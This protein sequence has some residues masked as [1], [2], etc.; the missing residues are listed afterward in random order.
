MHRRTVRVDYGVVETSADG[1]LERYIEKP[2]YPYAVSM[3]VNLLEPRALDHLRPG[4]ALGMPDLLMRLRAAGETVVTFEQ[5]CLWLDIGRV[6]DYESA[7][8]TF[9][10]RRSE[11][12]REA[13]PGRP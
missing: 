13:G 9:E 2:E 4:E 12:L 7:L 5:P 3:G 11:F 8:E 1:M 10:S 6:D